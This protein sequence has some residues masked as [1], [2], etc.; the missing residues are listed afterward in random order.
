MRRKMKKGKQLTHYERVLLTIMMH[1]RSWE[2]E[3]DLNCYRCADW[4]SG[5]CEGE[6][7][8]GKKVIECMVEHSKSGEWGLI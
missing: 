7:R 8:S 6:G 2:D 1:F 3:R 5:V 4:T